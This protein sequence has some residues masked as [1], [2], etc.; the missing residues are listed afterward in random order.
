MI[1]FSLAPA[2][3]DFAA[4]LVD[5][6]TALHDINLMIDSGVTVHARTFQ[7]PKREN[8]TVFYT[9]DSRGHV[10]TLWEHVYSALTFNTP[11]TPIAAEITR[12]LLNAEDHALVGRDVDW[13]KYDREAEYAVGE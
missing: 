11:E 12:E 3:R 10:A 7:S 13:G 8:V 6:R 9:L 4:S 5:P 1:M 2:Q